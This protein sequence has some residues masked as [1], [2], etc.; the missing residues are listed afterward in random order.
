MN[1]KQA[2]AG[3]YKKGRT[4]TIRYIVLHYTA[5]RGD[6]AKNNIDYFARQKVSAGAHYFVDE[7][8]VW[9]SVKDEDT[10]YHCGAKTYCHPLCRNGNSI[11]I[12]MCNSVD[13]VPRRTEERAAE[14][15]RTLM[16]RYG[17]PVENV[18]RHGDVTGKN[19]PAPWM[20]YPEQWEHFKSRLKEG[21]RSMTK[22]EAKQI[23]R[24]S[25]G[26]SEATIVYLD[27]YRYGDALILKL[28][29]A[30]TG[31]REESGKI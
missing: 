6:T 2:C 18:L 25:V 1:F 4:G 14:L 23:L 22:A 26:L 16:A 10:A 19:C 28:A 29:K 11:G 12:E 30:L 17:I 24:D 5:N 8:E 21:A 20:A 7:A 31:Q 3:N 13:G 27:A 15:T 9:Q